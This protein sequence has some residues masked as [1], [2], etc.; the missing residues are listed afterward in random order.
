[1]LPSSER[2]GECMPVPLSRQPNPETAAFADREV[3]SVKLQS[4][5]GYRY[6]M[7]H[8]DCPASQPSATSLNCAVDS[9]SGLAPYLRHSLLKATLWIGPCGKH[10]IRTSRGQRLAPLGEVVRL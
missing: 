3:L 2:L 8:S 7:D 6:C 4:K 5:I 1:M 9:G 10:R